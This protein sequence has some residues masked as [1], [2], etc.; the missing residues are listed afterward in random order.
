M[1]RDSHIIQRAILELMLLSA[2]NAF[3]KQNRAADVFK[4]EILPLVEKVLDDL[5]V[6]GQVIR[7]DKLRLDVNLKKGDLD[8]PAFLE[9][10]KIKLRDQLGKA[11]GEAKD[12][13]QTFKDFGKVKKLSAEHTDEE[14]FLYLLRHG[15]L[16]WWTGTGERIELDA[17]AAKVLQESSEGF[18]SKLIAQMGQEDVVKRLAYKLSFKNFSSVAA[19]LYP[20]AHDLDMIQKF[21]GIIKLYSARPNAER[22]LQEEMLRHFLKSNVSLAEI[23]SEFI[24]RQNDLKLAEYIY[25]SVA[26]NPSSSAEIFPVLIKSA[27]ASADNHFKGEVRKFFSQKDIEENLNVSKRDSFTNEVDKKNSSSSQ[28]EEPHYPGT[29]ENESYHV[30]NAG[31]IILAAFLPAFFKE[32]KLLEGEKFISPAHAER[33]VYLVQHLATGEE[34]G[35]EEHEMLL[36]KILC[37]ID[38]EEPLTLEF[39]LTEKEKE[40]AKSLLNAAASHW[41]ALRGTSGESMRQTFFNREASLEPQSNGWNLR[42]EKQTFDILVDKLPWSISLIKLPWM[43]GALFVDW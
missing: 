7:L 41:S 22:I 6:R 35:F 33:A 39:E 12:D 19:L 11:I 1:S 28:I 24:R 29:E 10:I 5:D 27:L 34:K 21:S 40:E 43:Q 16:P 13:A 32:M 2:D 26:Q 20:Q 3:E 31:V 25:R 23:I 30:H 42:I 37:G 4:R 8:D 18:K 9:S 17:L 14:L 38:I 15:R 36:N